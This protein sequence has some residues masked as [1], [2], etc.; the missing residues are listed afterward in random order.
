MLTEGHGIYLVS[1]TTARGVTYTFDGKTQLTLTAGTALPDTRV[2]N[3][4][5]P[6]QNYSYVEY[7]TLAPRKLTGRLQ[8]KGRDQFDVWVKRQ[9]ML[10]LFNPLYG[11]FTFN[12][13]YPDKNDVFHLYNVI[14]TDAMD[15]PLNVKSDPTYAEFPLT[16]TAL[17]PFWYGASHSTTLDIGYNELTIAEG[18]AWLKPIVSAQGPVTD[19]TI[20]NTIWDYEAPFILHVY[21]TI[22]AGDAVIIDCR[23][24]SVSRA[25]GALVALSHESTLASFGLIPAS[26]GAKGL[27]RI[28]VSS[29][30]MNEGFQ[31]TVD[32]QDTYYAI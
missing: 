6:L 9:E 27:N 4:A 25:S 10:R 8:V 19:L 28:T 15:S 7:R 20:T 3:S 23:Q 31:V 11:P 26:M 32:W 16:L 1:I 24:R 13:A 17:D 21:G 2:T 14:L 5:K 30:D 12:L 29:S 18:T 22:P